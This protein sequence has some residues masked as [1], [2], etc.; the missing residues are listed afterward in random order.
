MGVNTI[1]YRIYF[2]SLSLLYFND[3]LSTLSPLW[4]YNMPLIL[5]FF[6]IMLLRWILFKKKT[7]MSYQSWQLFNPMEVLEKYK[8]FVLSLPTKYRSLYVY[9]ISFMFFYETLLLCRIWKRNRILHPSKKKPLRDV[10]Q[11]IFFWTEGV[12]IYIRC[13]SNEFSPLYLISSMVYI[14]LEVH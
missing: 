4:L 8:F 11:F 13:S 6:Y 7:F 14:H 2:M 3:L 9:F 12:H 5:S 1:S 10:I